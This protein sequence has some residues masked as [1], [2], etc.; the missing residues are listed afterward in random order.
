MMRVIRV[1]EIGALLFGL[2]ACPGQ[3]TSSDIQR[4]R[5]EKQVHKGIA[6]VGTSAIKNF[7][8]LKLLKDIEEMQDQTALVTY[9]YV[10]NLVPTVARG[11]TARGGKFTFL[12]DSF[13]YHIPYATQF[14]ARSPCSDIYSR[15]KRIRRVWK[16]SRGC[17]SQNQMAFLCPL[18]Q[19]ERGWSAKTPR[20]TK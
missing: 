20:A 15:A 11:H 3:P 10:E 19:M 1:A 2:A 18:P 4:D 9:T 8:M 7:R 6:S 14:S 17:R 12:C 13:G 5:Q 16:A